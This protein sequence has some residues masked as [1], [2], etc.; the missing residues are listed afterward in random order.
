MA[1]EPRMRWLRVG[2]TVSMFYE[3][4]VISAEVIAVS[5]TSNEAMVQHLNENRE[6][7]LSLVLAEVPFE[8][9]PLDRSEDPIAGRMS[10]TVSYAALGKWKSFVNIRYEKH[11]GRFRPIA[12][13]AYS[14]SS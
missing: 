9:N 4:S 1:N 5:F 13:T 6:W 14:R 7:C 11:H 8:P 3:S 12:N 2:E 10:K